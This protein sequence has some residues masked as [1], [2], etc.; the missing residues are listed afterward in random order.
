MDPLMSG[1]MCFMMALDNMNL[2]R[3]AQRPI[4]AS[5]LSTNV[6][7]VQL[8]ASRPR[9]QVETKGCAASLDLLRTAPDTVKDGSEG[10][11]NDVSTSL[12]FTFYIFPG[13]YERFATGI[14]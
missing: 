13:M 5:A 7:S 14:Q 12:R 8:F 4:R 2:E 3:V 9:A 10:S 11:R 6:S 1:G